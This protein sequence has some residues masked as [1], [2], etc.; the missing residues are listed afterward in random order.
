MRLIVTL[1]YILT[2]SDIYCCVIKQGDDTIEG[3]EGNDILHGQRGDDGKSVPVHH[4]FS[5]SK[6]LCNSDMIDYTLL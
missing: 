6:F 5:V 2:Q 1:A 3:G 4:M